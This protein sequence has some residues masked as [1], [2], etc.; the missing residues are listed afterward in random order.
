MQW[1]LVVAGLSL[2]LVLVSRDAHG[3]PIECTAAGVTERFDPH[4]RLAAKR[5][6]PHEYNWCLLKSLCRTE[7]NLQPAVE[8]P[9]GAVGLCQI[10][11]GTW[12]DV[13]GRGPRT[14]AKR[15]AEAAARYLA[16]LHAFWI[17]PRP[18]ECR[19]ELMAASYNAGPG[20]IL[21]AQGI[22]G[23]RRC[24]DLIQSHLPS[25]TGRHAEET[26]AYVLRVWGNYRRLRGYGL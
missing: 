17:T 18:A 3:R 8:S 13:R 1:A 11:R 25:V 20:N 23:G 22:S 14:D 7:S 10:M 15:N 12:H 21:E 4:F 19:W 16:K 5:Y 26:Q 2:A 24:W 9:A 6:L